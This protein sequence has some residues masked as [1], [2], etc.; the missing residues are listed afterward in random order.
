MHTYPDGKKGYLGYAHIAFDIF[1]LLHMLSRSKLLHIWLSLILILSVIVSA[2][3]FPTLDEASDSTVKA[4]NGKVVEDLGK[5]L[6]YFPVVV[7]EQKLP[8]VQGEIDGRVFPLLLDLGFKGQVSLRTL[9]LD[10]LPSRNFIRTI[11]RTGFSGSADTRCYSISRIRIG[12]LSWPHPIL[13]GRD[14]EVMAG[15]RI[16]EDLRAD[17]PF[18]FSGAVGWWLFFSMNLLL[19]LAHSEAAVCDSVE[20]LRERGYPVDS[21]IE[22]PLLLD[23]GFLEFEAITPEGAMRCTLDTGCSVNIRNK[24]VRDKSLQ[25]MAFNPINFG[26]YPFILIGD[27]D[28]GPVQFRQLPLSPTL[29]LMLGVDFFLQ[30]QVFIDFRKGK[31][32]ISK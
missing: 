19:D 17:K 29:S 5:Y 3:F 22:T 20:T 25:D 26:E 11:V 32:F 7:V 16:L 13:E 4:E 28:L 15:G 2:A 9:E 24:L 14:E 1:I 18:P 31:I 23:R 27:S 6:L 21:W 30:H 8:I 12:N 10:K